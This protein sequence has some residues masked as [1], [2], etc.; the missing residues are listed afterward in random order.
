MRGQCIYCGGCK[1]RNACPILA[2]LVEVSLT[3][4]DLGSSRGDKGRIQKGGVESYGRR[5]I[6]EK[7]ES[8]R[9]RIKIALNFTLSLEL[10]E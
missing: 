10:K 6:L 5:A 2:W 1:R 3:S 8:E 9:K 4:V 7:N